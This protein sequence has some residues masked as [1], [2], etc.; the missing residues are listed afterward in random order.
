[1]QFVLITHCFLSFQV[2][3]LQNI[4]LNIY[5]GVQISTKVHWAK[6]VA[7]LNEFISRVFSIQDFRI[8]LG[9]LTSQWRVL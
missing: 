8:V 5:L 7:I 1:M 9:I 4:A 6:W 2:F 3:T